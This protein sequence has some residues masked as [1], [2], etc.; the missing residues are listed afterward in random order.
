MIPGFG[1]AGL[2]VLKPNN[3]NSTMVRYRRAKVDNPEA[4]YFITYVTKDRKHYFR[5]SDDFVKQWKS[6]INIAKDH[7]AELFAFVFISEH[8]HIILKQGDTSF[9]KLMHLFKRRMNYLFFPRNPV[10]PNDITRSPAS[11]KPGILGGNDKKPGLSVLND[12]D[13]PVSEKPG[14]V[15][16]SKIS[17]RKTTLWQSRFWEHMIR[18]DGDLRRHVEY[19]H[20]NPVKHG[21]VKSPW[22]YPYSSFKLFV[23]QGLYT[24]DWASD[25]ELDLAG[26][27]L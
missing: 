17:Q 11:P 5:Q 12:K 15:K 18:D 3:S 9:S 27:P 20:F 24:A 14:Y 1:E 8:S 26:E 10:F 23:E 13:S 6:W 2:R 21:L 22:D 16:P 19:I 4:L 25:I 7:N